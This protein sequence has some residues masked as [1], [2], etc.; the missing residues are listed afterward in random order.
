M[1]NL[2]E[3]MLNTKLTDGQIALF[4]L[5]QE[6]FLIQ[7]NGVY[8]LIDAYLSDYVD[9]NCCSDEVRWVRNYPAPIS[10]GALDFVDYVF[11]SHAHYDH[12]DP[13]TLKAI[14]AANGK[15]KYIVPAPVADTIADYGVDPKNIVR[16][17]DGIPIPLAGC[18]GI[19]TP[20]AA[21]HE[22]LHADENGNYRE[23]GYKFDLH[24][25]MLFHAGDCCVYDGLCDKL[26]KLDVA[27]LPVNGRDYFRLQRGIVGNMDVNEAIE[28]AVSTG[29]EL[30]VPMHFD[31]YEVNRVSAA[32]VAQCLEQSGGNLCYHIFRPGERFIFEK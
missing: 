31:L 7:Y 2:K 9:R 11:C 21:A 16:A 27:M 18:D 5:G 15:A 13:D 17:Y 14:S 4:Y 32:C 10:G 28:L 23:L 26:G 19:V 8:L 6:G 29:A 12:A 22:Q 20:V 1:K 3:K 25:T 24:G 30:L